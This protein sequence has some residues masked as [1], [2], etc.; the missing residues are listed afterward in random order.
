MTLMAERVL[1]SSFFSL[2]PVQQYFITPI[3]C[4]RISS[5]TLTPKHAY[6]VLPYERTYYLV[7][8]DV[9]ENERYVKTMSFLH[10]LTDS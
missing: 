4:T 7:V 2:S 9:L 1:R 5:V 6:N 3:R 8:M 10:F